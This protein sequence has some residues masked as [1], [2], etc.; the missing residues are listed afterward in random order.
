MWC[1]I[2]KG[3]RKY[4]QSC[5]YGEHVLRFFFWRLRGATNC[6][7]VQSWEFAAERWNN[8]WDWYAFGWFWTLHV[9]AKGFSRQSLWTRTNLYVWEL[10]LLH[11]SHL[12]WI[13]T[14]W[15]NFVFL[16]V[17]VFLQQQQM[18]GLFG[19]QRWMHY[20]L[21]NRNLT[22]GQIS[23]PVGCCCNCSWSWLTSKLPRVTAVCFSGICLASKLPRVLLGFTVVQGRSGLYFVVWQHVANFVFTN[24]FQNLCCSESVI[25]FVLWNFS[26]QGRVGGSSPLYKGSVVPP[27]LLFVHPPQRWVLD[28][29]RRNHNPEIRTS[30]V[31][32]DLLCVKVKNPKTRS[33]SWKQPNFCRTC[34]DFV[35]QKI[36]SRKNGRAGVSEAVVIVV[37]VFQFRFRWHFS[38]SFR[39]MSVSVLAC[40]VFRWRIRIPR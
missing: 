33:P 38:F 5:F 20:F 24:L 28:R 23:K 40:E 11:A 12:E 7:F 14:F 13:W 32:C 1:M 10:H 16:D 8:I 15:C 26:P 2:E 4:I 29:V 31:C 19:N 39:K 17:H 22:F 9:N 21:E 6:F 30:L 27:F 18:Q 35:E 34:P 37:H 3:V 36:C 25:F